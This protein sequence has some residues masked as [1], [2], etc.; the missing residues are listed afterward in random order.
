MGTEADDKGTKKE[1]RPRTVKP[2][3]LEIKA[4]KVLVT[5]FA[6]LDNAQIERVLRY[7]ADR[8]EVE[9]KS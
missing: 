9:L 3:D 1:R 5:A 7:L 6:D 4:M 2:E 8:F